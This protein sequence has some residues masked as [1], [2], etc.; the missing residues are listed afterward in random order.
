[1]VESKKPF[2]GHNCLMDLMK[3][4]HQFGQTLP[5]SYARFKTEISTMFPAVY[6]TKHICFELKRAFEDTHSK[7]ADRFQSTQLTTLKTR[8]ES[9]MGE[10]MSY[11]P[12]S[13]QI[14]LCGDSKR[15]DENGSA[16]EAGYD[17]FMTGFAF[18]KAA[19]YAASIDYLSP[20]SMR[21]LN[22]KEYQHCMRRFRNKINIA[23]A[24]ILCIN[25]DGDDVK[26]RRPAEIYVRLR[27]PNSEEKG[28]GFRNSTQFQ[29]LIAHKLSRYGSVDV[30]LLS[31]GYEAIVAISNYR[32]AK[33]ILLAFDDDEDLL[34]TNYSAHRRQQLL[35]YSIGIS[36]SLIL[37]SVFSFIISKCRT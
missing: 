10:N 13:P 37:I 18:L 4:Y 16:H 6:D 28:A 31:S 9:K 26:A 19:H 15:Y 22:F 3:L 24:S 11:L 14:T 29:T 27:R 8:L 23:R 32:T 34:V 2:V 20:K 35:K 21:P 36:S 25:L 5:K 7:F 30:K 17:A 12:F 1:L 33:D